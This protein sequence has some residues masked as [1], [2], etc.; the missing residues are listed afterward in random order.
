MQEAER[1]GHTLAALA[2][3]LG[4]TYERLA[5]WRRGE[6]SIANAK[7]TVHVRAAAYLGLPVVLILAMAGS[8]GLAEFV[9]PARQSMRDRIAR[10]L[11]LLRDDPYLGAFVP[12]ELLSA[13]EAIKLFVIF[14]WEELEAHPDRN[15]QRGA[16]WLNLLEL[17]VAA[18]AS[19]RGQ[20]A[21][22]GLF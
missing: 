15:A 1:R 16:R 6:G 14:L 20:P 5:Q 17:G 19:P 9:W 12:P 11:E 18:R 10:Q 7:R 3:A 4:V 22:G 13:P 21:E 8:L 2:Q